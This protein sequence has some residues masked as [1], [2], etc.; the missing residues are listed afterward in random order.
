L[1]I[2]DVPAKETIG[3]RE[4]GMKTRV[5]VVQPRGMEGEGRCDEEFLRRGGEVKHDLLY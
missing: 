1:L 2:L 5:C 3:Q 4:L